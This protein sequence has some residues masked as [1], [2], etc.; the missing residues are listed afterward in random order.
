VS[1]YK[2]DVDWTEGPEGAWVVD[3]SPRSHY[4]LFCS[5]RGNHAGT[6]RYDDDRMK[7]FYRDLPDEAKR[8]VDA[9]TV[10]QDRLM[11]PH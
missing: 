5:E 7:F 8:L 10:Q 11:T 2:A 9:T 3:W 6:K 1:V 4:H